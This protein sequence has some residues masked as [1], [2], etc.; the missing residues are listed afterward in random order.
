M[1]SNDS[2]YRTVSVPPELHRR[3]KLLSVERDESIITVITA[4]IDSL[5]GTATPT[6]PST[7]CACDAKDGEECTF[8]DA[9][10]H[11]QYLAAGGTH[12]PTVEEWDSLH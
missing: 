1:P 8:L 10:S 11:F 5:Q 6:E 7:Q 9:P 3:I 2:P 12:V 4:A